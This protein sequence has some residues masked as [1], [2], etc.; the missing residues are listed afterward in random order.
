MVPV[1]ELLKQAGV[2]VF[3]DMSVRQ[4]SAMIKSLKG[5]SAN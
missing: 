1:P 3:Y 4:A 2:R 5:G